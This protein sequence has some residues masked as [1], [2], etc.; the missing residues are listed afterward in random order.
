MGQ[1]AIPFILSDADLTALNHLVA[2]G[3]DSARK[4]SRARALQFSHQGYRPQ[5]VS[6][7]LGISVPTVYNIRKRYREEG[8]QQALTEKPRPG[9]P[10]KVTAQVEAEITAIACSEAPD[11][12]VRWTANLINDRL[13]KLD[14]HIHEESVRLALKKVNLNPGSKSN[15]VSV[16]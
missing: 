8:L 9:Q 5:Q 11:G 7:L 13:V 12:S 10:R 4:L 3:K 1:I 15:G 6:S 2:K 14:I 16:R